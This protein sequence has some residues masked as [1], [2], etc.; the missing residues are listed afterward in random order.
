M[1]G[2]V[3]DLV[4]AA[5]LP[6]RQI[7][8]LAVLVG[9]HAGCHGLTGEIEDTRVATLAN[10]VFEIELEV[11]ELVGEDE[12]AAACCLSFTRS[13]AFQMDGT[14]LNAP[15]LWRLSH[16]V[17]APSCEIIAVE[18]CDIPILVNRIFAD[19]NVLLVDNLEVRVARGCRVLRACALVTA[20]IALLFAA[21]RSQHEGCGC[22]HQ[23]SLFHNSPFVIWFGLF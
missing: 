3:E 19:V 14:V 16:A 21:T 23:I 13:G 17:A 9:R 18:K 12:V 11:L 1:V 15:A 8:F 6:D 22:K 5:R 7:S 4:L 10:L 2:V 20:A